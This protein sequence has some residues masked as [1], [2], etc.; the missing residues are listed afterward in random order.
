M[1][2]KGPLQGVRVIEIAGIGP[3][4]FCGMLLADLGADVVLV[5]RDLPPGPKADLVDTGLLRRGRRSVIVDLKT[6]GG[7]DVVHAL[8]RE[9]EVLFEGMRPGVAERLG[10]G[11]E[12]CLAANRALVYGRMTGWGQDG[13]LASR[14]GHDLNY[15]SLTGAL[16]AIGREAPTAPLNLV[17][18]FGGGAM[19]LAVGILAALTH[20]RRTGEGQV[21]DAA[22]YDGANLLMAM[23][24]DQY[25]EGRW[26]D[27]RASNVLDG[28]AP[29]NDS[30]RCADGRWLAVAAIEPQFR[31]RLLTLLGLPF[32]EDDLGL[33]RDRWPSL[34]T[35]LTETFATRP[36]DEWVALLGN[37]DACVTPV[38]S[39]AEAPTHA[40]ARARQSFLPTA[41]GLQ[42][43]PAP[44]FGATPSLPPD[45]PPTRGADTDDVLEGIGLSPTRIAA[46]RASGAVR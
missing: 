36:R 24:W 7:R 41:D 9:A 5:E 21:V 26:R 18:D 19:M 11:P 10:I 31:R 28:G 2:H 30:Y 15:I 17:G 39:L 3:G 45:P 12:S 33:G 32:T 42:P 20:A 40:H 25:G 44:R 27:E 22:M 14:A 38:L 34:R 16:H 23:F 6:D 46:L 1:T 43:A 4:P 37:D 35:A 8:A 29:F 13:P